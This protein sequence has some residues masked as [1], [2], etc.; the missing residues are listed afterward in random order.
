MEIYGAEYKNPGLSSAVRKG[1]IG[2][3]GTVAQLRTG[4]PQGREEGRSNENFCANQ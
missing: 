2:G 4:F 3:E 1:I